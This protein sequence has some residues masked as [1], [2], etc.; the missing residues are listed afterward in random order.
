MKK[1]IIIIILLAILGGAFWYK[2]QNKTPI[3]QEEGML[4]YSS[5]QIG[6]SFNYPKKLKVTDDSET[7]ILFHDI[8]F[9]NTG[10]CDMVDSGEQTY[11][12]LT[13]FNL[14]M[15]IYNTPLTETVK[16][17]SP[18]IPEE[19]FVDNELKENP[20]FIDK[21]T[22]GKYSGFM[23][24]EGAE[25]CG[26]TTYYFPIKENQ[27]T[28]VVRKESIQA[29]SGVRGQEIVNEILEVPDAVSLDQ[30]EAILN[31]IINSLELR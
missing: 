13:D 17:L 6:L 20:G 27:E 16:E 1:F 15:R 7:V 24:Y 30:S 10:A 22:K 8:A 19:N 26:F 14:Q 11:P 3:N 2:N 23:I 18:Y 9:E 28:L 25:G 31:Q 12:R 21:I 4:Q 5:E 29:L